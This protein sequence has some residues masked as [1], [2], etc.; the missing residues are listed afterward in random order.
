MLDRPS[1]SISVVA[2]CFFVLAVAFVWGEILTINNVAVL[3]MMDFN[4]FV[5]AAL[6]AGTFFL[7]MVAVG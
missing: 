3:G 5:S 4:D 6:L 7:P 2:A 1:A